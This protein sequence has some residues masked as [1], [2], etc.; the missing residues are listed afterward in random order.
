MLLLLPDRPHFLFLIKAS[1][2]IVAPI[3][4]ETESIGGEVAISFF[5]W[6]W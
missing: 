2:E 1:G 5:Q 4:G 6:F 3:V